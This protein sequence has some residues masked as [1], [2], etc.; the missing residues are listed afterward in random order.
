LKP[1]DELY[2]Q[3]SSPPKDKVDIKDL[4]KQLQEEKLL[5]KNTGPAPVEEPYQ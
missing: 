3:L 2:E 4:V 1:F 5:G